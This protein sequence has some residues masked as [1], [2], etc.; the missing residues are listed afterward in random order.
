MAAT[1]PERR[2]LL[3]QNVPKRF[4]K[5]LSQY[6]PVTT[7]YAANWSELPDRDLLIAAERE[8]FDVLVTAD[9]NMRHQQNIAGMS[10][11][12]VVLETNRW[13]DIEHGLDR[14]RDAV[15]AAEAGTFVDVD[16]P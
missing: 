3:D 15:L 10:I 16:L 2:I 4:T 6:G 13:N 9:R 11:A 5:L 12:V 7:A 1:R 14:V 8:G